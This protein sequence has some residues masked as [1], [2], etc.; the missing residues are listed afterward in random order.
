MRA[1]ASPHQKAE[2]AEA[3]AEQK[4]QSDLKKKIADGEKKRAAKEAAAKGVAAGGGGGDAA[5]GE[6]SKVDLRGQIVEVARTRR[7]TPSTLRRLT[8]AKQRPSAGRERPRQ[9]HPAGADAGQARGGG[10]QPQDLQTQG[11]RIAG[12]GAVRKVGRWHDHGA[13]TPPE[14][15]ARR[16][17]RRRG[18]RGRA[19]GQLNPKK[20]IWEKVQPMLSISSAKVAC[21]EATPLMTSKGPCVV[22]TLTGGAIG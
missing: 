17:R 6:F 2:T 21:F 8:W 3:L 18:S 20:K 10:G 4:K 19:R 22:D 13:P 1:T 15:C 11:G 14:A 9:V 7:P 16:A 5:G 12:D